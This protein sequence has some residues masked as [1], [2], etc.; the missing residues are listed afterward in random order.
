VSHIESIK[1]T[2]CAAPLTLLGGGRVATVTCLYCKS[3]LDLNDN[4]KV[5][6][7]FREVKALHKLPFDIG[8]KGL[9]K[10]IEYTIIGR[11]TYADMEYPYREWSD[12]LL[13]STLYGYAWLTY[14]EGTLTYSRR[15][16]TFPNLS[17][18][19]ISQQ[20]Q[21]VVDGQ[22]YEPYD[23]YAAKITYVEGELT[24]VAKK[25]DNI[26]FIDLIAP[27]L[28]LSVEK[29]KE[30]IEYY[31]TEYLEANEVYEAFAVPLE[32]REKEGSFYPLK[33]FKQ[34]F[35]KLL[36]S[37]SIWVL[38]IVGLLFLGV[39][40]DGQGKK[41]TE[42]LAEN[43]KVTEEVFS[44]H[45]T[46]YLTSIELKASN[47]KALNN[48]NMKLYK[49]DK[50]MFSLTKDGAYIFDY[51]TQKVDKRFS[52]WER[53]AKEVL[54]YLNLE[55]VGVYRLS[56]SPVNSMLTSR[57]KVTVKEQSARVNYLKIFALFSVITLLLYYALRWRYHRKLESQRGLYEN[58]DD[59]EGF[60]WNGILG[61]I[62]LI[63]FLSYLDIG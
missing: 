21:V 39:K 16:R 10:G 25:N 22:G 3:V 26:S 44:L 62:I 2:N 56:L 53:R 24:W 20:S 59:E 36:S 8:M 43:S 29:S 19:E 17:W 13:F 7:N 23:V 57:V 55:R 31:K 61:W 49:D 52:S 60:A 14:E 28:G 42:F 48:F 54:V 50:L 9:L 1:C 38:L 63:A 18:S 30:E 41:L 47:S 40:I 32:K 34:P 46:K 4:Y 11:V 51:A 58:G 45:S 6:S 33:P 5:L 35:F 37:I 27:P 12:F 15:N